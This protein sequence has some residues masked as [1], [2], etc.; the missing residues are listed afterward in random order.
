MVAYERVFEKV[1]VNEWETKWLFTKWLLTRGGR[2]EKWSPSRDLTVPGMIFLQHTLFDLFFILDGEP[3]CSFTITPC[4][5]VVLL[6]SCVT[7]SVWI[8]VN[9]NVAGHLCKVLLN[10]FSDV[11]F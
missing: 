8:F 6:Q 4:A 7:R 10:S 11:H 1:F 3:A 2:L 5:K 9:T